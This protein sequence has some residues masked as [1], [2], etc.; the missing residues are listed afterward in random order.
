[1]RSATSRRRLSDRLI[2]IG[3]RAMSLLVLAAVAGMLMQ[4]LL[5]A[6]PLAQTPIAEQR[7]DAAFGV[8]PMDQ[9]DDK[10]PAWAPPHIP[11][12][13]W[14]IL[15]QRGLWFSAEDGV[16]R[17]QVV[18]L[19][20]PGGASIEY[21]LERLG[22]SVN[23]KFR[24]ANAPRDSLLHIEPSGYFTVRDAVGA[25]LFQGQ[26]AAYDSIQIL[27]GAAGF[28]GVNQTTIDHWHWVRQ[29]GQPAFVQRLRMS[30][31]TDVDSI[32]VD[33]TGERFLAVLADFRLEVRSILSGKLVVAVESPLPVAAVYWLDKNQF[34][35][36]TVQGDFQRWVIKGD[37][38]GIDRDRLFAPMT[39]PG[40]PEPAAVWQPLS[41]SLGNPAKLNI[42]PLLV[43]TF[44]TALLA[45]LFAVPVA[46]GAAAF[47]GYF[48]VPSYRNTIKPII[49]MIAAFPTVVIG[50]IFALAV[51][52]LFLSLSAQFVGALIVTPCAIA[53]MS[54]IWR[55]WGTSHPQTRGL[56]ALPLL[57]ALPGCMLILLGAW[58]GSYAEQHFFGGDFIA[59]VTG[60]VGLGYQSHNSMLVA[61]A[62]GFAIIPSI[63]TV[64]EDAINAVPRSLGAGSLALGASHWQSFSS[65]VLPVALPGIIAA[66]LLGFG[67]A[68]GET[69]ILL[70][71]SGN[72]ADMSLN[73]FSAVRSVAATL[74]IELPDAA[75]ASAHFQVLVLAALLLFAV[76]FAFNTVAQ[77]FKRRLLR[78]IGQVN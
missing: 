63:F 49:E 15:D 42:L 38:D 6:L 7:T 53:L 77:L 22:A 44:K 47:V 4:L 9:S 52:P 28:L 36:K 67:R 61:L 29:E 8:Q 16:L 69:M 65:V 62:M 48:M 41:S 5:A 3:V 59:D 66:V 26:T 40:Y 34:A 11:D 27:P 72:A 18:N 64:A 60:S 25:V 70:M 10:I 12:V 51:A 35:L 54:V 23:A 33:P 56:S 37:V 2:A 19:S 14:Q 46:T 78:R 75:L 55:F 68:V 24:L 73:P 43:G 45:L 21:E 71:L 76:S 13:N 32:I 50:A 30:L 17:G 1:M 31:P 74:A 57:L 20:S 58:L 39:Y